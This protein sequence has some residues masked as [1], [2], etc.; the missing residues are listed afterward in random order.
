MLDFNHYEATEWILYLLIGIFTVS[1]MNF[2]LNMIIH[3][4]SKNFG[5]TNIKQKRDSCVD[6]QYFGF[7]STWVKKTPPTNCRKCPVTF[8]CSRKS[9][10]NQPASQKTSTC[11][12]NQY[13]G[14]MKTWS[15]NRR[16]PEN[17]ETCI[18][19][20]DCRKNKRRKKQ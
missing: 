7:L 8:E 5:A 14:L 1:V 10:R 17:C 15:K 16:L 3:H 6:D 19:Y 4:R 13:F 11:V 18:D 20:E 9:N 2:V 12:E